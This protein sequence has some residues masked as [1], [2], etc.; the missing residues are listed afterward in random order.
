[1]C[2]ISGKVYLSNNKIEKSELESMIQMMLHRG[3]DDQGVY[4]S[5]DNKVGLANVRL[6]IID[7]SQKGHQPMGYLNRYVITYNGEMYNFQT[8][9][10]KLQK[11]GYRFR[12]ESDT[13]VI[14]ALYDKYKFKCLEHINGMFA[15]A[16][17]DTLEQTLFIARDRLG[18]KPVKYYFNGQT[19]IFASE[20]KSILSQKEVSISP[21]WKAIHH[22]LTFGFAP[23]PMTGFD[24]IKKI[25]PGSYI[26]LDIRKKRLENVKYWSLDYSNKL[27][28]SESEWCDQILSNLE[29]STRLRMISDVPVGAFLSGGVDSSGVVATMAKLS[30]KPINTFTITFEDEKYNESEFARNI[31]SMYKTDHTELQARPEA[32][33][34]LLPKLIYQYEEP[35][36]NSSSIVMYMVSKLAK[37]HVTVVLNGDGGDENFAGYDRFDKLNRDLQFDKFRFAEKILTAPISIANSFIHSPFLNR[38]NNFLIKSQTSIPD[39]FV[40]YNCYFTNP[41]KGNIYTDYFRDLTQ[42][43]DSYQLTRSNFKECKA[44]DI[45]DK[46]LYS[47]LIDYFPDDLLTKV[48]ISS[49]AVSLESRSP[50]LDYRMVELAAKIPFDLKLRN[51]EHKYILKKALEKIVPKENLYRPKKGFSIPLS[52]WFTGELNKYAETV[53]LSKRA[54]TQKIFKKEVI[55]EML[56]THSEK[57][58]F[59]PKLWAIL[60]LELWMKTFFK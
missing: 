49:M 20:L 7:L 34:E 1:M 60:A 5:N 47:D 42:N 31:A 19:L 46:A 35:Y 18:K 3:P 10:K 57:T 37:K 33:E 55:R 9:K 48:D 39:R 22:Y 27:Y 36:A 56:N 30:N 4:L 24:S 26:Y 43:W 58:D 51:G 40:T 16:L 8:E 21:D 12:S 23:T 41:E 54:Y 14:L 53:L 32:I 44:A 6:A 25:E 13:E 17:Y 59:G 50:F 11:M 38:A 29:D 2:G 15:F 52:I 28:L 45:R